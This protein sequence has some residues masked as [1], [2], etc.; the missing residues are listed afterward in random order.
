MATKDYQLTAKL[1]SELGEKVEK[2]KTQYFEGNRNA[3]V[4]K[5]LSCFVESY[6][7]TNGQERA[8]LATAPNIAEAG[9]IATYLRDVLLQGPAQEE[10]IW[11]DVDK[12]CHLLS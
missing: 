10:V 2:L 5:A 1:P 7:N 12:L 8:S 11:K 3:L 6:E 4:N 9:L